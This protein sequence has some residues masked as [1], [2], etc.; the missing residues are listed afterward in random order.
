VDRFNVETIDAGPTG[1]VPAN[2][3]PDLAADDAGVYWIERQDTVRRA[4]P[5]LI[6]SMI[7]ATAQIANHIALDAKNVYWTHGGVGGEVRY[8]SRL[9]GGAP[10]TLVPNL[11]HPMYLTVAGGC[12]YYAVGTG[13]LRGIYR[14]PTP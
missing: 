8:V 1:A 9:D 6:T 13:K 14:Y 12:V 10:Q 2:N 7:V 11:D 5:S 4:D 3:V